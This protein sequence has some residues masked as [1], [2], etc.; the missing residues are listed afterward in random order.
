VIYFSLT[1][2][3]P[4]LKT[5]LF[6]ILVPGTVTVYVPWYLLSRSTP[7]GLGP[8]RYLGLLPML[9]GTATYLWC[10]WD[11]VFAGKG[12]PAPIDAP[13]ELVVRGLYRYIRNPMYAGVLCMLLGETIWFGSI[14]LLEYALFVFLAVHLFVVFYEEPT[15][16]WKFGASYEQ[17]RRSVARWVPRRRF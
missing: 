3:T 14:V 2:V 8:I 1:I 10:A 6:T 7:S 16:S 4:L 13:R 11:F 9:A 5:I 15:L 12:T 17:Y